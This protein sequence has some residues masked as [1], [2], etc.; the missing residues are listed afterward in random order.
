MT[1]AVAAV[2]AT[3]T[4]SESQAAEAM[5]AYYKEHNAE[6]TTDIREL[7]QAHLWKQVRHTQPEFQG[8]G[9][10]GAI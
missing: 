10:V 1:K 6:L 4:L 7:L 5:W 8:S 2:C 3:K 9:L